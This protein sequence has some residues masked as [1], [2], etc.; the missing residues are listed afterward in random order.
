M[1]MS[2]WDDIIS[3]AVSSNDSISRGAREGRKTV[4]PWPPVMIRDFLDKRETGVSEAGPDTKIGHVVDYLSVSPGAVVAVYDIDGRLIGIAVDDDVMAL[5]KRDGMLSALERPV[6]D[7]V[8]R[9]RPVCSITDSP[10]LVVQMMEEHGWDRF[11][12]SEHGRIVGVVRRS[13][14]VKFVED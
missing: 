1:K 11:G 14:L 12:V 7:A 4:R 3:E 2:V 6:L 5:I 10:Y 9:G 13:D 8:H